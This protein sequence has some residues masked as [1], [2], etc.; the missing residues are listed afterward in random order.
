M[1]LIRIER[2]AKE[3]V[4]VGESRVQLHCLLQRAQSGGE[5]ARMRENGA[6]GD[7]RVGEGRIELERLVRGKGRRRGFLGRRRRATNGAEDVTIGERGPGE[8]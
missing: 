3:V 7:V 8:R 2:A 1:T 6:D 5:I 4:R